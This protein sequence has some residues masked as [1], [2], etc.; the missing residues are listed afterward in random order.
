[1]SHRKRSRISSRIGW[2]SGSPKVLAHPGPGSVCIL[3][4]PSSVYLLCP[5]AGSSQGHKIYANKKMGKCFA[6]VMS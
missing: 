6:L 5:W 3:V 2:S 4:L 1:M